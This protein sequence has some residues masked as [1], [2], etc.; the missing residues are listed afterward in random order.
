MN[1]VSIRRATT[2]DVEALTPLFD[3][4]RQFY[5]QPSDLTAARDY[6]AVRLNRDECVIFIAEHDGRAVG[7]TLLYPSFTSTQLARIYVLNDLFVNPGVRRLGVGTQLLDA[8]ADFGR[9]EGAVRLTL[10]TAPTNLAAQSV[11]DQ[12]GWKR[13]DQFLTYHRLL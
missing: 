2:A 12:N 10:R 7:F 1:N 13:D 11:Y 9:A 3:A 8:A 5:K 4:Y 6:L